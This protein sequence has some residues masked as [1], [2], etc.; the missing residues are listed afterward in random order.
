MQLKDK[1]A[2]ITG[3]AKGIGAATALR[4][5]AEGA[6]VALNDLDESGL[7]QVAAKIEQNGGQCLPFVGNVTD[8]VFV[9]RM[10]RSTLE[11]FGTLDILVNN[12]GITRDAMGH[13]MSEALW[14]QVIEVNLKGVFNCLQT[15]MIPMIKQGRGSIINVS[16]T[17]RYGNPGQMNYSAA[18][19]GVVSLTRTAAKELGKKG[20]RVNCVSPGTIDTEMLRSIPGEK[21]EMFT[22]FMVPLARVG[23]PEEVANL[24]VF[25]ASGEASYITGQTINVDGGVHMT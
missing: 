1:V 2:I 13:K 10:V 23:R 20:V 18:K 21:L 4:F 7:K 16:S 6:K 19:G 12:A 24:M 25:L 11:Q 5:V 15:A 14:D 9:D 22:Q 3:A 17:S 8:R